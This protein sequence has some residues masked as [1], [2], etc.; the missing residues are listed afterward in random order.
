MKGKL[1]LNKIYFLEVILRPPLVNDIVSQ[2][3]SALPKSLSFAN[4]SDAILNLKASVFL[5][6]VASSCVFKNT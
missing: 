2:P 3:D 6:V 1:R 4:I 5:R